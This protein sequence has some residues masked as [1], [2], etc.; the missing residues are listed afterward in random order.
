MFTSTYV[1]TRPFIL[2]NFNFSETGQ[3]GDAIGGITASIIN[4][5]G[6]VLVYISFKEQIKANET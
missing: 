4:L 2:K 6:A 1:F 5:I 3:I